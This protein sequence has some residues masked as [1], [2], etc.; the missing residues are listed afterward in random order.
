MLT[1]Q[2]VHPRLQESRGGAV[3]M[4]IRAAVVFIKTCY[5]SYGNKY[6]ARVKTGPTIFFGSDVV[7]S[8]RRHEAEYV[9]SRAI[10]IFKLNRTPASA[11]TASSIGYSTS[12]TSPTKMADLTSANASL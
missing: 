10:V 6:C 2:V 12:R 8:D 9:L 5:E 3:E 4:A 7:D 1:S 11:T